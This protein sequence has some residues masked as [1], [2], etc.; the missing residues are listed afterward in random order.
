MVVLKTFI[1]AFLLLTL[2]VGNKGWAQSY[3]ILITEFLANNTNGLESEWIELHNPNRNVIDLSLYEIGDAI[4]WKHISD[5]VVLLPGPNYIVLAQ[6]KE[7][8]LAYYSTFDGLI[9]EPNSWPILNNSGGETVRLRNADSV[10]VD[11][12]YYEK[13]FDDNRSWERY[14]S[15]ENISYWGKSYDASGST[16]GRANSFFPNSNQTIDLVIAPNPFSPDGDGF[17]DETVFSYTPPAEGNFSLSIYD[18]SGRIVKTIIEDAEAVPGSISWNGRDDSGR[19]LPVGIY[20]VFAECTGDSPAETK[21]TV[22]IA[23]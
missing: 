6:N 18:I 8:F 22:V 7:N 16:P 13:T 19:R 23:R 2:F 12:F 20:I 10:T 11:S 9:V 14:I 21:L 1:A 3:D 17:E 5:T 15:G 4:G